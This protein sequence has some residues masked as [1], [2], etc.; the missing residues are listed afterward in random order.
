MR[1]VWVSAPPVVAAALASLLGCDQGAKLDKISERLDS[2]DK[3]LEKLE[4]VGPP[5][6]PPRPP[7]PDPQKV[8][9]ISSDG[10]AKGK[11]DALVT[12]VEVSDFQ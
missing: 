5:A 6:M 2:M 10:R 7:G 1:K 12:V 8:Y 11:P 3:K 4:K 9:S